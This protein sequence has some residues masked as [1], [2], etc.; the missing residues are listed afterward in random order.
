MKVESHFREILASNIRVPSSV[1]RES[2]LKTDDD[3]LDKS[4]RET[5]VQQPLVVIPEGERYRLVK[6]SRRLKIA[7]RVGIPKL[8]CMVVIPPSDED[9]DA[10]CIRLRFILDEH[11]QDLLPSQRAESIETLKEIYSLSNPQLAT[12]LGVA[13]DTI[14]NWLAIRQ[15]K[16]PIVD[17]I[18]SGALTQKNARVFVGMTEKG[19]DFLWRKHKQDI[20]EGNGTLH[21]RIRKEYPPIQ[22]PDL[23]RNASATAAKLATKQSKTRKVAKRASYEEKR[24]ALDSFTMRTTEIETGKRDREFF[25]TEINRFTKLVGQALHNKALRATVPPEML[26]ELERFA[27]VY[28]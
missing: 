27:E 10:F 2:P 21:E 24:K 1:M 16:K 11:R 4:I 17:A 14:T 6:G 9:V 15:Y 19:Q 8:P 7:N 28:V 5:G 26:P 12:R 18:D 13:P 23:Y 25:K 20:C 3:Y 22:Y